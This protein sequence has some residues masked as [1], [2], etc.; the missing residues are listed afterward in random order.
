MSEPVYAVIAASLRGERMGRT[1]AD[2]AAARIPAALGAPPPD[3]IDLAETTLPD[4]EHL[5]PGGGRPTAL[6]DRLTR[7]D[8]YVFITPEY[9]HSY[10]AGLKRAIDWHYREWMFKPATI[11]SYGV[12]GGLLATEHLRG[13]LAE[14]HVVTTRRVLGL[15]TPWYDLGPAGYTP[16]ESVTKGLDL[17][18]DELAWW[19]ETLHTARRERPYAGR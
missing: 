6:T 14:L 15:T 10:P 13:V 17:A 5:Q 7:A 3:L 1:V 19:T 2:W 8:A 16:P 9:N 18:L 11:I 12:Q 4:D